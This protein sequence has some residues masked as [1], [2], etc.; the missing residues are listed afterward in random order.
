MAKAQYDNDV[1]EYEALVTGMIPMVARAVGHVG[2][3]TQQDV[4]S[5]KELFPKI[6]DNK[7]LAE[8]KLARVKRII[9]TAG[10]ESP[11]APGEIKV[12]GF[13]VKKVSP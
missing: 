6:T 10:A 7:T 9:G 2:V 11:G 12:G 5:V 13:T 8:N 4:D 1:S 3:L